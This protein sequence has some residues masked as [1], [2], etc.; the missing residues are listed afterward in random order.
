MRILIG[1]DK[2]QRGRFSARLLWEPRDMWVGIFW[3][4]ISGE[5]LLSDYLIV[6]V[7]LV[8][9]FPIAISIRTSTV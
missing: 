1:H 9:F 6:Y 5:R 7:C 4:T 8:P 3:N 2:E